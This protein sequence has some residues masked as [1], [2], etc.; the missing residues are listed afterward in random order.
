MGGG[1]WS[2]CAGEVGSAK[3]ELPG[4]GA[5]SIFRSEDSILE[6]RREGEVLL[7]PVETVGQWDQV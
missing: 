5:A 2:L 6:S 1:E 4:L 3:C 7:D